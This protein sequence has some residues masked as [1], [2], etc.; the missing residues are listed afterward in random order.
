MSGSL[1]RLPLAAGLLVLVCSGALAG[2][3]ASQ[4]SSEVSKL[5]VRAVSAVAAMTEGDDDLT[6]CSRTRRRLWVDGE[7]WI[8]R[9]VTTCR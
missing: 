5:P 1:T 7:G 9:R 4:G 2:P 6:N 8:V 3:A